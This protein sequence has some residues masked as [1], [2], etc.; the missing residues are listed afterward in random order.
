MLGARCAV[1]EAAPAPS[2]APPGAASPARAS[3]LRTGST[4]ARLAGRAPL[5]CPG[6]PGSEAA[7]GGPRP[8]GRTP[9]LGT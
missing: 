9:K 3:F 4:P 2:R 8:S 6:A 1:P 5:P 7:A